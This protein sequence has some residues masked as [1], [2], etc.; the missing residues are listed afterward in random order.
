MA[1]VLTWCKFSFGIRGS[2]SE[3]SIQKNRQELCSDVERTQ[4]KLLRRM[5]E[6]KVLADKKKFQTQPKGTMWAKTAKQQL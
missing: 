6:G 4:L 3:A 1:H 2:E 5:K